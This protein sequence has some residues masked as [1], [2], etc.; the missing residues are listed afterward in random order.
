MKTN[1]SGLVVGLLIACASV[2]PLNACSG[3]ADD[4]SATGGKANAG[5][6]GKAV[7][8]G[9]SNAGG[10]AGTSAGGSTAN[11]GSANHGGANNGGASGGS[12]AN[13]GANSGGSFTDAGAA[14]VMGDAGASGHI[15]AA[16][17]SASGGSSASGGAA[18]FGGRSAGSGG[19]SAAG[20]AGE[21]G[22]S[23][24]GGG[25]EGGS[26]S[27]GSDPVAPTVYV[28]VD[29]SGSMFDCISTTGAVE[30]ACPDPNDTVWSV[31]KSAVLPVIESKQA[32]VRFG[33]ASFTGTNPAAGGTCPMIDR[34]MPATNNFQS[35]KTLYDALTPQ[36]NTTE[37]GKKFESP[38]SASL[39]TVGAALLADTTPGKKY[40]ILLTD[41]TPDYCDDGPAL[42]APD[43]VVAR[44]QALYAQGITTL[45][46]GL[47][48]A[49]VE[50]APGVL[51]AFANAG[52]GE[53]TLAPLHETQ[54]MNA[55]Y[56][57]CDFNV[58]WHQDLV[59]SGKPMQRGVTLGTYAS[60]AGP[61][62]PYT[63]DGTN[64]ASITAALGAALG[65]V[66]GCD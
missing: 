64:Q 30:P 37:V 22:A 14:G 18:S 25:N 66:K 55:F 17:M 41:G 19:S 60:S 12:A 23:S 9:A 44:L 43:S 59:A 45:V 28:M 32:N 24:G 63:P 50:L 6:G 51:K 8:G 26:C 40:I 10:N 38:T 16:G 3:D 54:D 27:D 7:L 47:Q 2:A 57:L 5:S 11:G 34:V 52:A 48:A 42:C 29:R 46:M 49:S 62:Q 65:S 35:I 21:G 58:G 61:S 15:G 4:T 53:S 13:G 20:A 31:L 36:P 56:D 39:A 33:F 1:R